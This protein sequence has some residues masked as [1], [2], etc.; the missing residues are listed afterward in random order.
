MKLSQIIRLNITYHVFCLKM[1]SYLIDRYLESLT[2]SNV[3]YALSRD[4]RKDRA[5]YGRS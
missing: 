5:F 4:A 1:Q 2:K 3:K